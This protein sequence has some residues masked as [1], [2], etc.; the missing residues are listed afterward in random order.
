[1]TAPV[2][3]RTRGRKRFV[4]LGD[5]APAA[6][7][8][9]RIVR[10]SCGRLHHPYPGGPWSSPTPSAARPARAACA[11]RSTRT[12]A[13][14]SRSPRARASATPRSPSPSCG[15]GLSAGWPSC[16]PRASA[17]PCPPGTCPTSAPTWPCA[18]ARPRARAPARGHAA[19]AGD[20]P[21]GGDRALVPAHGARRDRAAP[22]RGGGRRSAARTQGSRSASSARAGARA[23]RPGAMSFNWRLLLGPDEILDYVVWHEACHLVVM[24]HSRALLDA[25][26]SATGPTI[27]RR[28][29]GC[30]PTAPRSSS[31]A[32]VQS[33]R[34]HADVHDLGLGR[35][36]ERPDRVV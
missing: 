4:D 22:R 7:G 34:R 28:S 32:G 10:P 21:R 24:D 36:G 23:P 3:G 12:P 9:P 20:E 31:Q 8:C 29:A 6:M 5:A 33:A 13:S 18:P 14:R 25:R 11:W 17:W 35:V 26:W 16:T 19:R 2:A 30:A 1:M 27:A 15:R